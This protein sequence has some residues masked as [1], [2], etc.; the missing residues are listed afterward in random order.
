MRIND[1]ALNLLPIVQGVQPPVSESGL[2]RKLETRSAR[3]VIVGLGYAGLPMAVEFA[4][5]GFRV[6]GYD[7]D[8]AKVDLISRGK[9]PVSNVSDAEIA[10]LRSGE[11]LAASTHPSVLDKADVAVICVPTP[12]TL[13]GGPDLRFVRAAGE[14]IAA[15]LRAMK[16]QSSL[17]SFSVIPK[18]ADPYTLQSLRSKR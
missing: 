4:R 18:Q 5:A 16:R 11:K 6:T 3:I 15:H 7:V 2:Q 14:T 17:Q 1:D 12:L 10:A 9:S 13:E 8:T